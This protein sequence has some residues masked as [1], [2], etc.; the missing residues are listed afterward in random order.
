[1]LFKRRTLDFCS[2]NGD[3]TIWTKILSGT[4]FTIQQQNTTNACS[5]NIQY[6]NIDR[7]LGDI[8]LCGK[9]FIF[10]SDYTGDTHIEIDLLQCV[11]EGVS[12]LV[13][14]HVGQGQ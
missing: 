10:Y 6:I 5:V 3:V 8:I 11:I 1:M 9:Q 12:F 13:Y 2:G 4:M 14:G 7:T